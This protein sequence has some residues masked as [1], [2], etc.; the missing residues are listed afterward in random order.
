MPLYLSDS[1]WR[2]LG[3]SVAASYTGLGLF[4]VVFPQRATKEFF[5]LPSSTAVANVNEGTKAEDE[6][7]RVMGPLLGVRDLSIA[8]A[9]WTFAYQGKWKEV[10]TVILAGTILCAADCL[11]V[12]RRV[13]P[14]LGAQFTGGA[15]S[16]TVI[17]GVLF[18]S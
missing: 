18:W 7:I 1:T 5:A 13:G 14:G 9:M 15:V 16:W 11:V 2:V 4:E 8:A 3:L 6:A 12:W 17:G 10:G